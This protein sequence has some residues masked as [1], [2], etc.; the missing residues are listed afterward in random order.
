MGRKSEAS[1]AEALAATEAFRLLCCVDLWPGF[2]FPLLSCIIAWMFS[3]K[4]A[5]DRDGAKVL[6]D[7]AKVALKKVHAS[8]FL[9]EWNYMRI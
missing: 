5:G 3:S 2:F 6:A 1:V 4:A 9:I 7:F 8:E